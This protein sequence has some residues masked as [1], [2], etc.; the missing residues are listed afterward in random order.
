MTRRPWRAVAAAALLLAI[1]G[2]SEAV[3]IVRAKQQMLAALHITGAKLHGARA[4][5]N[6]ISTR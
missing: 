6:E 2:G 5:I 1:A 3:R 4:H